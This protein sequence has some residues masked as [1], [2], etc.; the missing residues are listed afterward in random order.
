VCF[1]RV[2]ANDSNSRALIP[3]SLRAYRDW[4]VFIRVIIGVLIDGSKNTKWQ[5]LVFC[6]DVIEFAE[7]KTLLLNKKIRK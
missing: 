1:T 7:N 4:L 6:E 3:T 5:Y 2:F